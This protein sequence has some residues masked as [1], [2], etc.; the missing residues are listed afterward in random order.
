MD[1]EQAGVAFDTYMRHLKDVDRC[2]C[3]GI[4]R[5]FVKIRTTKG[6]DKI[7]GASIVAP[8]A[9]DLISELTVC[10]QNGIGLADLAGVMH[11]YPTAAES[12]RQCAAQFWFSPHFKTDAKALAIT[13]RG[14]A[15]AKRGA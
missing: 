8:H 11:P 10:M 1:L 9:G 5:G 6:G 7:L 15:V 4:D 14:E 2:K 12:I 13:R 3:D